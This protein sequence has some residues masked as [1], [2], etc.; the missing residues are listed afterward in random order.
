[1][2]SRKTTDSIDG[3]LNTQIAETLKKGKGRIHGIDSSTAMINAA[4]LDAEKA[5]V[6]K[7][8]TFEGR[9]S[10]NYAQNVRPR[11]LCILTTGLVLDA[12]KIGKKPELSNGSYDKVFSNAAMHVSANHSHYLLATQ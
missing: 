6:E 8:C 1:M 2:I 10:D 5:G 11:S 9:L 4:R 7:I 12:T 3:V